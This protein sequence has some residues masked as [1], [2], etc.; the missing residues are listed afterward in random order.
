MCVLKCQ[1]R[2]GNE[3]RRLRAAQRLFVVAHLERE[4]VARFVDSVWCATA[5]YA[6]TG[7]AAAASQ[8]LQATAS[9]VQPDGRAGHRRA[10]AHLRLGVRGQLLAP[11]RHGDT[12]SG[13]QAAA[14][15]ADCR[16]SVLVDHAGRMRHSRLLAGDQLQQQQ[17]QQQQQ[18]AES[19]T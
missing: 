12:Q 4:D 15:Q 13:L 19:Q 11:L 7:A 2:G 1:K 17:Q 9:A 10:Q 3:R 18:Q 6:T 14:E 5:A 16:R 8:T